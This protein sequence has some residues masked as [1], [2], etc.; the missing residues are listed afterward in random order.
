MVPASV[1]A[2]NRYLAADGTWTDLPAQVGLFSE[3]TDGIVPGPTAAEIGNGTPGSAELLAADGNWVPISSY[4]NTQ[5]RAGTVSAGGS[6]FNKVWKTDGAGNPAW[7]DEGLSISSHDTDGAYLITNNPSF[8]AYLWYKDVEVSGPRLFIE[9]DNPPPASD[10]TVYLREGD[11]FHIGDY[12]SM[13]AFTQAFLVSTP[14]ASKI[15]EVYQVMLLRSA[16]QGAIDFYLNNPTTYPSMTEIALFV[17]YSAEYTIHTDS[18]INHPI[19]IYNDNDLSTAL[20]RSDDY[21][22]YVDNHADLAAAYAAYVSGGGTQSKNEWGLNHYVANGRGEGRYIIKLNSVGAGN[23]TYQCVNHPNAMT[24]SII[25]FGEDVDDGSPASPGGVGTIPGPGL[26]IT[27]EDIR[28]KINELAI[29]SKTNIF[30]TDTDGLVPGPLASEAS[31]FLRGDGN[32]APIP[33]ANV[34]TSPEPA[35]TG[36]SDGDLWFNETT[37]ELYVYISGTGWVQTNGGGAGGGGGVTYLATP[38]ALLDVGVTYEGSDPTGSTAATTAWGTNQGVYQTFNIPTS[39]VPSEATGILLRVKTTSN[40]DDGVACNTK[41]YIKTSS[42][43]ERMISHSFSPNNSDDGSSDVN[44]LTVPYTSSIDIKYDGKGP[45][46]H[47]NAKV[48]IDGYITGGGGVGGGANVTTDTVAPTNPSDGDLWFDESVGKLYVYVDTVSAWVQANG[49]GGGGGS[50]IFASGRVQISDGALQSGSYN[51]ASSSLISASEFQ[52]TLSSTAPDD[53]VVFLTSENTGSFTADANFDIEFR[54]GADGTDRSVINARIANS[55]DEYLNFVVLSSTTGGGG[56]AWSSGWVNTDGTTAVANGATL[57]FTHGLGTTDLTFNVYWSHSST[58]LDSVMVNNAE[59]GSSGTDTM[60]LQIQ[61]V[62]TNDVTIQLS[63]LG[64]IRLES[65]GRRSGDPDYDAGYIKVVAYSGG[66]GGVGGGANVTTDTVAPTNPS[67]GD[68]WFDE[69]VG[70]LYV[71][72]DTVSAWV[73]ANG[74]GGGGASY[75]TGWV[76]TDGTNQ[77]AGSTFLTFTHNLGENAIIQVYAALDSSGDTATLISGGIEAHSSNGWYNCVVTNVTSTTCDIYLAASGWR[78]TQQNGTAH[79]WSGS[80][81]KVIVSGGGGSG[82]GPRAYVAFDGSTTGLPISN[83]NNISSI[84]DNATGDYTINYANTINNPVITL[85]RSYNLGNE[86]MY[87][88]SVTDNSCRIKITKDTEGAT[89]AGRD[90]DY[91]AVTIN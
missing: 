67:D 59:I 55:D 85:G 42:Y 41:V 9:I 4:A 79:V 32:W 50:G 48:Y 37:G 7:R 63:N 47:N 52:I 39:E 13:S 90:F 61:S 51:T 45:A 33:S 16:D 1:T 28:N 86:N 31:E 14:D 91:I 54:W 26:E 69:S 84:T 40:D 2:D 57:N 49:G 58:G 68:L 25:V 20:F 15:E 81:I 64:F 73:Q 66:G 72:V 70:K 38:Y 19:Y 6:N 88:T 80:Y 3:D 10:S 78:S 22:S 75:S 12:R 74:G 36:A 8:S 60:G 17:G 21:E 77:V 24:G 34:T 46:T 53:A 27:L 44:N 65:D 89:L 11:S 5:A 30:S 56:G 76:N 23:F 29:K 43:A 82:G 87:L 62:T 35:P 18:I 71:Y 83:S